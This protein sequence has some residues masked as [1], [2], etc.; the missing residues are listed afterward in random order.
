MACRTDDL[1]AP[2]APEISNSTASIM[3]VS[4]TDLTPR[5]MPTP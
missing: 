5:A 4:A 2:L 3:A 1:A